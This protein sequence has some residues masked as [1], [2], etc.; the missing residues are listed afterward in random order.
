MARAG[1]AA[2]GYALRVFPR[3][4]NISTGRFKEPGKHL[5]LCTADDRK[6]GFQPRLK[7]RSAGWLRFESARTTEAPNRSRIA[8]AG[9]A[10]FWLKS[11]LGAKI[12]S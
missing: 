10:C 9:D 5:H 12:M 11:D 7:I 4:I 3:T 2:T 1:K 6:V 8:P